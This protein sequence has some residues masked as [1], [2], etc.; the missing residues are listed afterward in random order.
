MHKTTR[1]VQLNRKM[2]LQA[3]TPLCCNWWKTLIRDLRN[4]HQKQTTSRKSQKG[5]RKKDFSSLLSKSSKYTGTSSRCKQSFTTSNRR[6]AH[7]CTRSNL[8]LKKL[9]SLSLARPKNYRSQT[10]RWTAVGRL[11]TRCAWARTAVGCWSHLLQKVVKCG[12]LNWVRIR[13][14]KSAG[15]IPET[16]FIV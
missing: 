2:S 8:T 9:M 1:W 11:L 6:C 12:Q 13:L 14:S 5:V 10:M 4:V 15:S 7:A 16:K 3:L